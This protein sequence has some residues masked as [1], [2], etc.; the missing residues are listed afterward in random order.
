[1]GQEHAIAFY[2][3]RTNAVL[4][5]H[6]FNTFGAVDMGDPGATGFRLHRIFQQHSDVPFLGGQDAGGM[7][8]LGPEIGQLGRLVKA[9]LLDGMGLTHH[10]RIVIVHAINVGPYLNLFA[11]NSSA[12]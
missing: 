2:I 6:G 9:Q 12:N 1:M 8:D 3:D 4:G 7:Q 5:C 10:T 11:A